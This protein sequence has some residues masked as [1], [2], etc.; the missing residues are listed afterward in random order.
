MCHCEEE[1]QTVDHFFK[2]KKQRNQREEMIREMK[3][4]VAIGL[5]RMK[6]S[7]I[8]TKNFCEIC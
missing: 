1:E 4:L 6:H 2:C 5:Q 7:L 3:T 8:I